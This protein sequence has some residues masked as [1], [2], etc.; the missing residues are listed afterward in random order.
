[1][2]AERPLRVALLTH[3]INPRGGVVH[4]LELAEELTALGHA[5]TVHAPGPA[6]ARFF[7]ETRYATRLIP[8]QPTTGGL[9]E[10]VQSRI[11]RFVDWFAIPGNADFD[12]FHAHDGIGANAL[13]DL[14]QRGLIPGYLRTV[15]HLDTSYGDAVVD[16]LEAR[17][18]HGADRLLCVSPTWQRKLRQ[19]FGLAAAIVGNGV[20]SARF[21]PTPSAVDTQLRARLGLAQG[22]NRVPVFLAVGGIEARKN[23]V[24]TL[25]AFARL[26]RTLGAAQL[27]IA[28]GASLLDHGAYQRQFDA[29][30]AEEG[31]ATGPGEAV[32]LAGV[33]ADDK[34]PALYR[35]ADALVFVSLLE[36]FGLAIVEAMASGTPVVVSRIAPFTG[37]LGA[38]DC[39]W[40]EPT[41]P[42]SIANAMCRALMPGARARLAAAGHQ[43]AAR[44]DWPG[45]ARRHLDAYAALLNPATRME[46]DHA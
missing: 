31:L 37:F 34:M 25:R 18:I 15:H 36:G 6:G 10:L 43:V 21:T 19:R 40:A 42:E 45:C 9:R 8:E 27:V 3:S 28:G 26:R 35:L 4:C 38:D 1:M 30:L 22:P 29:S 5:V 12:I 44:H 39:L 13:L 11:G 7:R 32:I 46:F 16:A 2:P 41:D 17:S 23:T 33:L 24:A 14:R 20:D